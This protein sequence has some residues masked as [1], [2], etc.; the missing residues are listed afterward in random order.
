MS[1][2]L[3]IILIVAVGVGGW[4]LYANYTI[5]VHRGAQGNLEYVKVV[6]RGARAPAGGEDFADQPPVA[7]GRTFIRIATFDVEGLD[8]NKLANH[9]VSDVLVR[10]L[11]HFD[12]IALQGIR[13]HGR[14]LLVRLVEQLNATGKCYDFASS[15]AADRE[16]MEQYNAIL[17]DRS[18]VDVDRSTV[19][20]I[21][22]PGGGFRHKPLTALFRVRGPPEAE[23]F[24]FA[25]IDVQTDP[26][27]AAAELDLLAGVFR[28]VRDTVRTGGHTEDD[29]ILLGDLEADHE[30][31]GQLGRVPN[32]TAAVTNTPTTT[33]GTRLADNILF[34][35]RAT[36]EF[37]GRSG[38]F[39]LMRECDL[40]MQDALEVSEHMPVWAE[41][42]VYEN[43]QPGHVAMK[44]VMKSR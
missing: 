2:L 6:P 38:V 14:G 22:D 43:G 17:F 3:L 16:G 9:R 35:R 5:E 20:F 44:S 36:V 25:L 12:V 40:S 34:D 15:P 29:V 18:S 13:A 11:P 8:E 32:L 41:F 7:A 42:S 21:E 24:T 1:R 30:H 27:R 31:L 28:A 4:Y 10:V 39:D 26:N 19:Q 23:A 37:T 33:R